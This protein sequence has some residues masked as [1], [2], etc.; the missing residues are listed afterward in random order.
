[1]Q[2]DAYL[3]P[4]THDAVNTRKRPMQMT[5]RIIETAADPAG[6]DV[7]VDM[8]DP[9]TAHRALKPRPPL[10]IPHHQNRVPVDQNVR[11]MSGELVR[12]FRPR[13]SSDRAFRECADAVACRGSELN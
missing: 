4:P 8:L 13:K 7:E 2:V 11:G 6:D 5:A 12:Y 3:S 9:P 10:L 1:M